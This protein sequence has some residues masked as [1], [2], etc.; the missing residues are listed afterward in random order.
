MS[1]ISGNDQ[2][3]RRPT[4]EDIE[5]II[6]NI[7]DEDVEEINAIGGGTVREALTSTANLETNSWV[8]ERDGQIH[9]IFGVNPVPD[10]KG[11][12]VVWMLAT[13]SFDDHLF[14]FTAVCREVVEQMIKGYDYVFNYVYEEN[15]KSIKWLEWLG[16][17]IRDAEGIGVDG[18][19]F[20]RFE[21]VVKN[22]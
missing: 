6:Q 15:R 19:K 3:F 13:K 17:T 7:R 20:H 11:I 1:L 10:S 12:G 5:F 9:A 14:A 4:P 18:A 22:V 21:M 2:V 16:F 8:W